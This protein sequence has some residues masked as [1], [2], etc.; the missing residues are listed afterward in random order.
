MLGVVRQTTME[1]KDRYAPAYRIPCIYCIYY[2][3]TLVQIPAQLC[4]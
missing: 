1:T 2:L 4:M 3:K